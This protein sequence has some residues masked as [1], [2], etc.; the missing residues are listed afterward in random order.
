MCA[1][2]WGSPAAASHSR[3][4]DCCCY[5]EEVREENHRRVIEAKEVVTGPGNQQQD[6]VLSRL[7]CC[8][9]REMMLKVAMWIFMQDTFRRDRAIKD[10]GE[11]CGLCC[12]TRVSNYCFSGWFWLYKFK[13]TC[14]SRVWRRRCPLWR[15]SLFCCVV[16]QIDAIPY[17]LPAYDDAWF[18]GGRRNWRIAVLKGFEPRKQEMGMCLKKKMKQ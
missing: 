17:Q 14:T 16:I 1:A 13:K 8:C 2:S 7:W 4:I 9:R 11:D 15:R 18:V 10:N 5:W 6:L 3:C 12:S